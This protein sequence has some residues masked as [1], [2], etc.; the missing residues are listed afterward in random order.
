VRA[1]SPIVRSNAV[2]GPSVLPA[3]HTPTP[4]RTKTSSIV[5]DAPF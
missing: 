4:A 5:R 1:A 3:T 2:M